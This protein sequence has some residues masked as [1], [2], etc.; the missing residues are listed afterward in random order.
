MKPEVH[1]AL[2]AVNRHFYD[3]FASD[4]DRSREH[5]W[6]GWG[7]VADR[8][9]RISG[10][11]AVLDVGCGNGR[12]G[13]F[14]AGRGTDSFRYLGIDGCAA[15]LRAAASRLDGVVEA[16]E[17]RRVDI[18]ETDVDRVLGNERF[19]LVALF[20]VL[21]HI[22]GRGHRRDLI[23]RLGHLLTPGGMLAASIWL[24][25]RRTPQFARRVVPWRAFNRQQQRSGLETLDAAEAGDTLLSWGGDSEHPRYC[26]FPDDAE[27]DHWITAPGPCLADRFEADGP[28]GRDNLYLVWQDSHLLATS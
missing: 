25:D 10:T 24:P 11:P 4:F 16:P 5:P 14:L 27:I 9:A 2:R 22:P 18:L 1:N 23:R 13:V 8:L 26:H 12:F 28:S 7:R 19:D 3:R 20:G 17:L 6:P 15:L 21:H